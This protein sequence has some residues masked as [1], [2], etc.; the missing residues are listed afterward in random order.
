MGWGMKA[1]GMLGANVVQRG[2]GGAEGLFQAQHPALPASM[3]QTLYF[4]LL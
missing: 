2:S 1:L 3:E 4:F